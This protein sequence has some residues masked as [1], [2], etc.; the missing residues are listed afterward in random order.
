MLKFFSF[1]DGP[2]INLSLA[3][4][5]MAPCVTK[6]VGRMRRVL[7]RSPLFPSPL[8]SIGLPQWLSSKRVHLQYRK[9][10]FDPWVWKILW[11]KKWQPT[12][13]FLPGKSHGQGSLAGYSSW[14]RKSGLVTKLPPPLLGDNFVKTSTHTGV[15]NQHGKLGFGSL[16]TQWAGAQWQSDPLFGCA[17]SSLLRGL[18]SSCGK[19]GLL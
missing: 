1:L 11:R 12:P 6:R 19:L 17:G 15:E 9:P 8:F 2:R 14:G 10:G 13:V 7:P 3:K 16:L 5:Y 18:F 4:S